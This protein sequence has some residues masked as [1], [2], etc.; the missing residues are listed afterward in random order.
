MARSASFKKDKMLQVPMSSE[1]YYAVRDITLRK[2]YDSIQQVVRLLLTAFADETL[3]PSF[4]L[5]LLK[6]QQQKGKMTRRDIDRI[7][8]CI[9]AEEK[10]EKEGAVFDKEMEEIFLKDTEQSLRKEG[11]SE[12]YI[13]ATLSEYKEYYRKRVLREAG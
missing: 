1:L 6:E 8:N 5:D 2:G 9:K 3:Q 10:A 13:K 12:E 11:K 7:N 4:T